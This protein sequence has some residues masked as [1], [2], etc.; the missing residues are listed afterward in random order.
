MIK[1]SNEYVAG[2][3]VSAEAAE[4]ACADA[5]Y[6]AGKIVK[7]LVEFSGNTVRA[8]P[9]LVG[10]A[11]GM[12]FKLPSFIPPFLQVYHGG[13]GSES[14]ISNGPHLFAVY[15]LSRYI[16]GLGK[17]IVKD[18]LEGNAEKNYFYPFFT[19]LSN[20]DELNRLIRC[21]ETFSSIGAGNE[22][23]LNTVSIADV[24]PYAAFMN[25]AMSA[26]DP[27]TAR[28]ATYLAFM[29]RAGCNVERAVQGLE[30]SD[31]KKVLLRALSFYRERDIFQPISYLSQAYRDSKL[32]EHEI[33][34]NFKDSYSRYSESVRK[35]IENR[36]RVLPADLNVA[37]MFVNFGGVESYLSSFWRLKDY[38]ASSALVDIMVSSL[39][40]SSLDAMVQGFLPHESLVIMHGGHSDILFPARDPPEKLKDALEGSLKGIW[41]SFRA[42]IE[43]SAG[44]YV[45]DGAITY[46]YGE[47]VS[48][49]KF[50]SFSKFKPE[51]HSYGLH[52][53]CDNC[54]SYPATQ[55][56]QKDNEY[57]CESCYRVRKFSEYYSVGRKVRS[58]F[59]LPFAGSMILNPEQSNEEDPMR[60]IGGG[61]YVT[62]VKFDGND[63]TDY[64]KSE[65]LISYASKSYYLYWEVMKDYSRAVQKVSESCPGD[66]AHRIV[67]G[68]I[69]LAGDEGVL[70]LPPEVAPSFLVYFAEN[71]RNINLKVGALTVKAEHPFSVSVEVSERLMGDAKIKQGRET[72]I[73]YLISESG[74]TP[75]SY[76]ST[77]AAKDG[78]SLGKNPYSF[79]YSPQ[80]YY[81]QL[82]ELL[83]D[84]GY[85][86]KDNEYKKYLGR[87]SNN[88]EKLINGAMDELKK[89]ETGRSALVYAY[90]EV[91]RDSDKNMIK[92][93]NRASW[94]YFNRAQDRK[95]NLLWYLFVVKSMRRG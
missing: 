54:G 83:Q 4:K 82:K 61:G 50:E 42:R 95:L 28:V 21:Y 35:M 6:L 72:T 26:D 75:E 13:K 88:L 22:V 55:Y 36:T 81:S 69:Y 10:D 56:Y 90:R 63:M 91:L 86:C 32:S 9:S 15:V 78:S 19:L 25:W 71:I 41:E 31:V 66:L 52:R 23:W 27:Y 1:T 47:L 48:R 2:E 60:Y 76:S 87:L 94:E 29:E 39:A 73:G 64:F 44:Y 59:V 68:T 58:S 33:S 62:V 89:D 92:I 67:S 49:S 46:N 12:I 20:P 74:I 80:V 84:L 77:F 24:A 70:V 34:A 5:L 51:V 14:Q 57:L 11:L 45:K 93:M 37:I 40:F 65:D 3:N 7:S 79:M 18:M 30:D 38:A 85:K 8:S 53:V 16:Q 17:G 43:V